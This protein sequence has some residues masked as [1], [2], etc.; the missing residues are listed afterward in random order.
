[1]KKQLL[2]AATLALFSGY[3]FAADPASTEAPKDTTA[4]KVM[5]SHQGKVI[6]AGH[7]SKHHKASAK[8][9]IKSS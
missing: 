8:H 7:H 5:A 6:K 1:M 4:A 3:V 9:A 2:T